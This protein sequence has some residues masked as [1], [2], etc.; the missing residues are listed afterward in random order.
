MNS[1]MPLWAISA[2][3]FLARVVLVGEW[4][5]LYQLQWNLTYT[6]IYPPSQ[7]M[8]KLNVW[9]LKCFQ[10]F[11][12]IYQIGKETYHPSRRPVQQ[13]LEFL[14]N[15]WPKSPLKVPLHTLW[16]ISK[17]N[18]LDHSHTSIDVELLNI[19][20]SFTFVLHVNHPTRESHNTCSLI[21]ALFTNDIAHV[22]DSTTTILTCSI[23]DHYLIDHWAFIITSIQSLL[24]TKVLLK[25]IWLM[26]THLHC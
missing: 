26:Q 22:I 2:Y 15:F 18:F 7:L 11:N 16:V 19:F 21:D 20:L 8:I 25:V 5:C 6:L 23:S 12:C 9:L 4:P 13:Y 10:Y 14:S 17:H 24:L 3:C 1:C